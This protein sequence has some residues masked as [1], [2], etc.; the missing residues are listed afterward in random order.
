MRPVQTGPM[1]GLIGQL[2]LLAA[3]AR[4]VGLSG[5]GWAVGVTYALILTAALSRGLARRGDGGLGPANRVTLSRAALVGGVAALTADS[6]RGATP[7][8]TLVAL[9]ATAIVLDAVD[10]WVARRTGTVSPL[11]ARFDMELDAFL[12][13]ALS[14]YVA[15]ST[16]A[17]VLAIG[18]A[19]YVF[20][21]A[22]WVL[23]WLRGTPPPRYWCKVV[24]AIQG[25]VLT[26]AAADVLPGPWTDAA[27][28]ASLALLAE[29]FGRETWWLWRHRTDQ[30]EGVMIPA[31]VVTIPACLL[32]WFALVAPNELSR[33]TVGA[34]VRIPLE[35]LLGVALVLVLPVRARQVV[36]T[37]V[38]VLLGVLTIVKILDMGFF[39]VL[40]RPF[41]PVS[42]WG[43]FGPTVGVLGDS[44]GVAAATV[45]A[46]AAVVLAL[47]VLVVMPLSVVRLS[48]LAAH[49]RHGSIRGVTALG[50]TWIVCAALGVHLSPDADVASLSAAG[51]AYDEVR[52]VR[53]GIQDRQV[54]ADA[55]TDD[56]YQDT[57]G[58]RLLTGLR[59]KDV[60]VAF[61][62]SYGRVAVQDSD[63]SPRVAAVLDEGTKRLRAAGFAS[64]SAFLTSP[65]F[66]AASWLAHSTLQSGL[67]VD[68]QQR[69]DQ[70]L[71]TDRLTLTGAFGR[72]GWRTVFDDPA[73]TRD[74]PEG[75]AFYH[76]DKSYDSRNVGYAGPAF[77]YASMPDQY[78][79][80]TFHRLELAGT[81]RAPVMAEIDLVSSHHPWT[82][83][84]HLVDWSDLGD[85]SV[86]NGM[87]AQG[88][89]PNDVFQD[90]DR[91]RAVYGKSIEYS[92]S[93]LI[94]FVETYPDPDLVLV[95]LGDH[96][97]HTYVTGAG[98]GHDV[99]ITI[100]AH[101]RS[102]LRRISGWGWEDGMRPS[103]TAPVWPMDAFR[104]RFL[105]AYGPRR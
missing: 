38:G 57:A 89:S 18:A 90:S 5:P 75:A 12:I 80:S 58:D 16:G 40:D 85:G 91:V 59:G 1:L 33:I 72:A 79:L 95:L 32:V 30:D 4:T 74:W 99:P 105:T 36:A 24:A 46:A 96:Q 78:T 34:F 62:E 25:V 2:A 45:S 101:D 87:P 19:R 98:G 14:V 55:I 22:G 69:Y 43:Y 54:F 97:P 63:F 66:G 94:S 81:H 50:V 93:S 100:V 82:P 9:A 60:I 65:T 73:I 103:P 68:S 51:L 20:V 17:W 49:H 27:L 83:L 77:S 92:L 56:R 42:D 76:F 35:G 102:V 11:G 88:D 71:G 41:D 8:A 15:P 86:F 53:A 10:G 37:L 104:D 7:V 3:L 84:P 44:I 21:A 64:R 6:F 61:V 13:L 29:S 31:A 23:P 48:R 47:A 28:A 39:A 70:L 52:Q 67:W 26:S